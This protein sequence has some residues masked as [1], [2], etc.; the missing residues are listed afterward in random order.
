MKENPGALEKV[1]SDIAQ[2]RKS[3][4]D[5]LKAVDQITGDAEAFEVYDRIKLAR[6]WAKIRKIAKDM[7]LDLLRLEIHCIRKIANLGSIKILPQ[8]QRACAEFY[9]DKTDAEIEGLLNEFGEGVSPAIVASRAQSSIAQDAEYA[10]TIQGHYF[11]DV[12]MPEP[13]ELEA[14]VEEYVND[15]KA[16]AASILENYESGNPEG[17]YMH[18]L[19]ET[20][21]KELRVD[22]RSQ[23]WGFRKGM[24]EV[25]RQAVRT[26]PDVKIAGSSAPKY[27]TCLDRT[28][29][30]NYMPGTKASFVRVPFHNATIAQ[31]SDM[32]DLRQEQMLD[33]ERSWI[34]VRDLLKTLSEVEGSAPPSISKYTLGQLAAMLALPSSQ[35]A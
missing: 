25:C 16:A 34:R 15:P 28:E 30:R 2:S 22:E 11:A 24:V 3:I 35:V 21:Y 9:K 5:A 20:L 32:V 27:I 29:S 33:A 12:K 13:T 19:V 10:R 26:A 7:H 8:Y 14:A 17:F 18:E 1:S 4:S 23:E 31:L 6:E